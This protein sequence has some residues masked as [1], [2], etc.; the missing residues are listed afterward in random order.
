[1][2]HGLE[3]IDWQAPW[4]AHLRDVG[5]P[6]ASR[7]DA[8]TD[9]CDVLNRL[10]HPLTQAKATVQ[11]VPQAN[12][13]TGMPYES[14]IFQQRQ[15]P[16]RNNLHDFFN[17]L[18]WLHFP[19]T[20]A[21]LNQLHAS[22]IDI[23]GS[24]TVRGKVR[25]ALTLFDENAAILSAPDA[26]WDALLA[27]DWHKLFIT[28]RP[29][30]QEAHLVLFGHALMEKLVHPRKPICAHVYITNT[31]NLIANYPYN[32]LANGDF[33]D[34]LD[35]FIAQDLSSEKCATKPFAPLPVLGVPGWWAENKDPTFYADSQVFRVPTA[36]SA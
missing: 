4:L 13:P 32:T 8:N 18:C 6:A 34:F 25:D 30:W 23:N 3:A 21:R 33:I 19:K 1:M 31:P 36:A 35:D 11:F 12:L 17:G 15:C 10:Q 9:V 28:L 7:I 29:L 26:L 27:K 16:T 24:V 2:A 22:Q 5:E 20:K 14:C